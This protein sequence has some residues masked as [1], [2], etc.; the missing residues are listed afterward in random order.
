MEETIP[1]KGTPSKNDISE[2]ASTT[3]HQHTKPSLTNEIST[4][5]I[6]NNNEFELDD[7]SAVLVTSATF[8]QFLS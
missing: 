5:E 1:K 8:Y 3:Q 6:E 4:I 7:D 2:K